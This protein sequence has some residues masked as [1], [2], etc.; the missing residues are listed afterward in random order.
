MRGGIGVLRAGHSTLRTAGTALDAY[1]VVDST[2]GSSG[3]RSP[4]M[5]SSSKSY[6]IDWSGKKV[7]ARQPRGP[8]TR[9][10]APRRWRDESGQPIAGVSI[11]AIWAVSGMSFPLGAVRVFETDTRDDGMFRI[12]PW[13]TTVFA[14]IA[15]E[16]SMLARHDG[17]V[18]RLFNRRASQVNGAAAAP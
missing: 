14:P 11:L 4:S 6:V 16:K 7:S 2:H 17:V 15:P 10:Q 18:A 8:G 5:T 12:A 3:V 13:S 9:A 1:R